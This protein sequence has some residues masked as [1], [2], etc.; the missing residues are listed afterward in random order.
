MHL[1]RLGK[2]ALEFRPGPG[3]GPGLAR[4]TASAQVPNE[5]RTLQGSSLE[6]VCTQA[7]PLRQFLCDACSPPDWMP[8]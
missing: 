7:H 5:R 8:R 3:P 1:S 6:T 2:E 4:T